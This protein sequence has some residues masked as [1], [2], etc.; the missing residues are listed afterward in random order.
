M[1]L[2]NNEELIEIPEG[3][4]GFIYEITNK[5]SGR[6]YIGRKL[7]RFRK[8]KQV[9]GKKKKIL[10][11]S[12]W[13]VYNSSSEL[14]KEDIENLG[15]DNF[16][17]VILKLCQSKAEL[18]YYETKFIFDRDCLLTDRYYNSWV[19]ARIRKSH[20]KNIQLTSQE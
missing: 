14:L 20:L 7:F 13:K 19:S 3:Y 12:D 4:I 5:L 8:T 11:E 1:W 16:E 17:K 9:K 18:S 10:A 15:I 2:Y 6:K